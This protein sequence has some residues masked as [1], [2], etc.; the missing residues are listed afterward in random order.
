LKRIYLN[1]LKQ[2]HFTASIKHKVLT[3]S[4]LCVYLNFIIIALQPFGTDQFEAD[5]RF[6]LLFGFGLVTLGVYVIHS[7]IENT[8][9]FRAGKIWTVYNEIIS[10]LL[11]LLLSGTILYVYN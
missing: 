4:I 10:T 9:Y 5:Y 11:F 3:G 6:L 8:W 2:I 1:F 7:T